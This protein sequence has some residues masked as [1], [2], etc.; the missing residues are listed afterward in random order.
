M[1]RI[2]VIACNE[3]EDIELIVPTDIWRRAGARVDLISL[4][5][6]NSIVLQTGTKI[7]CTNT[8]DRTNLSQYNAIYLP[9]GEGHKKYR[10]DAWPPKNNDSV[11]RLQT[12]LKNFSND[13]K[14][15][16][17]A[18]SA[19]PRILGELE[20]LKN[21]KFTCYPGYEEGLTNGKFVSKNIVIDDKL[22]TGR[23]P[24]SSFE[25]AYTVLG[26]FDQKSESEIVRKQ[27]IDKYKQME[28]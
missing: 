12:A 27:I 21:N 23:A 17:L 9:G 15:V 1:L 7:S 11:T 8:I 2:A 20:L 5:K 14:K 13:P 25:F 18:M 10:L 16:I 3:T 22:I 26:F 28:D 19:A 6:K 24:G 4:E